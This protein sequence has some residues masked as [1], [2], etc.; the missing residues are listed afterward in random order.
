MKNWQLRKG[1]RQ[2]QR[3]K[4][5]KQK[6]HV[7]GDL[8]RVRTLGNEKGSKS[9]AEG[10]VGGKSCAC[11]ASLSLPFSLAHLGLFPQTRILYTS[12]LP[13]TFPGH[14]H[15]SRL[16]HQRGIRLSDEIWGT[17]IKETRKG[18][19]V[20]CRINLSTYSKFSKCQ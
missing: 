3:N 10:S 4:K 20:R 12:D 9:G 8:R 6:P 18:H 19:R 14:H 17:G 2:K 5:R 1:N 7:C 15:P 16:H 11:P 13:A